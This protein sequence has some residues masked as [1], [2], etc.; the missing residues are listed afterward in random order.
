MDSTIQERKLSLLKNDYADDDDD[1]DDVVDD[2]VTLEEPD[3]E[4]EKVAS[5]RGAKEG[6]D[7]S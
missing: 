6:S 7:P 1:D 4:V 2:E 5:Y 3:R